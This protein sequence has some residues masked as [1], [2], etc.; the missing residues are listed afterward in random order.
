V[1]G[2]RA[3]GI[4]ELAV[5]RRRVVALLDQ[6][7]LDITRVGQGDAQLNR[8]VDAAVAEVVRLHPFDVE[9]WPHPVPDPPLHRRLDVGHDVADLRDLTKD[10]AHEAKLRHGIGLFRGRARSAAG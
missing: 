8:G 4:E 1:L 6:L 5:H 3:T 10:P 7:D 9:P 2:A